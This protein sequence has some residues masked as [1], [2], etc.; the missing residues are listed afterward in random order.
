LYLTGVSFRRSLINN[1]HIPDG[2]SQTY[3]IGEKYLSIQNQDTGLDLGD[4]ETWCTGFNNDNFR[5]SFNPP[6]PDGYVDSG[7]TRNSFGSSHGSGVFFVWCDGHVTYES[8]DIDRFV[9]RG[10][11]NRADGGRPFQ[12]PL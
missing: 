9:H 1:K 10:N 12:A 2:L 6:I 3:L 5:A 7:D 11:A 8:F 4:N